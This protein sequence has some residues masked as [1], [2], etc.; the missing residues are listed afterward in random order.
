[1]ADSKKNES[2]SLKE[3]ILIISKWK[4]TLLPKRKTIILFGLLGAVLGFTYAQFSKKNYTAE[5]T[6]SL[7]EKS[8]AMGA[9]AGI[10]SQFGLDL[11][12][13]EAGVFSSDNIVELFKSRL[14][15]ENT[16]L[17]PVVINGKTDLLI[18]RF[19]EFN[20]LADDWDASEAEKLKYKINIPRSSFNLGQDSLLFIVSNGIRKTALTV[21]KIDKKLSIIDMK[22]ISKDEQ[23][24][25]Y[26][27]EIMVK[28]VTEFY[29]ENKTKKLKSNIIVIQNKVD[30]VKIALDNEM[31]TAALNQ[32]QN[33]NPSNLL[34]RVPLMK[35]QMN[36]QI[37][38][39]MYG[40]LLKNLEMLKL[41]LIREEPLIQIIDKP[42]LPLQFKK[43][44]RIL[45]FIL[46]GIISGMLT[47]TYLITKSKYD[48]IMNSNS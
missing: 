13:G 14:I 10:A 38:T 44:S 34:Q 17:T 41:T 16:L 2:I 33:Q 9:Y 30:S 48:E 42:I 47:I 37:L 12:K 29:V 3:L 6:F 25:K 39:T 22:F 28:N 21:E 23:F 31:L 27:S 40:E 26:F 36:I 5:L 46:G 35:R 11:G 19:I 15:I 32:D 7:D 18:N 1:M 8:G 45:F 4:K 24:A 20:K 43:P